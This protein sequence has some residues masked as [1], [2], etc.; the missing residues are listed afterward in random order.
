M[1]KCDLTL[2]ICALNI[3]ALRDAAESGIHSHRL[4]DVGLGSKVC[5]SY[6]V[7]AVFYELHANIRL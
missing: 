6:Q 7:N 4:D 3:C 1:Y 5:S 2:C